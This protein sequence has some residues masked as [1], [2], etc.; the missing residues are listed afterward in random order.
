MVPLSIVEHS[1][2]MGKSWLVDLW[3]PL[4]GHDRGRLKVTVARMRGVSRRVATR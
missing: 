1:T 4:F 2:I 3:A